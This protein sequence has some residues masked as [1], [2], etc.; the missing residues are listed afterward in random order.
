MSESEKETFIGTIIATVE[1][2][3]KKFVFWFGVART[4]VVLGAV[5]FMLERKTQAVFETPAKQAILQRRDDSAFVKHDSIHVK[6]TGY[7]TTI[8]NKLDTLKRR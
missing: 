6:H 8:F 5:F 7:F 1:K 2:R 3:A 4:V